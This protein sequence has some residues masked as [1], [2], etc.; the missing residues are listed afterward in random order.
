MNRKSMAET[1]N[2]ES[3]R[4][5]MLARELQQNPVSKSMT[6]DNRQRL[7]RHCAGG[8]DFCEPGA[9]RPETVDGL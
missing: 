4:N 1:E 5:S 7:D 3:S 2:P 9:N 8:I 6:Y